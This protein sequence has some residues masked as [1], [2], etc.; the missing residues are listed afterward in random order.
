MVTGQR[1]F[2]SITNT[3]F[4]EFKGAVNISVDNL[5]KRVEE[6]PNEKDVVAYCQSGVRSALATMVLRARGL[7]VNSLDHGFHEWEEAGYPF[8]R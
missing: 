1:H 6:I 3:G 7:K 8:E 5:H 2:Q 4:H